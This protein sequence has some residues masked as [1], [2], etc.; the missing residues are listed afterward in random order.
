MPAES[1]AGLL[2]DGVVERSWSGGRVFGT[3]W[4]VNSQTG[5]GAWA[6]ATHKVTPLCPLLLPIFVTGPVA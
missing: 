4:L 1:M 3:A 6:A 2:Q 5:E